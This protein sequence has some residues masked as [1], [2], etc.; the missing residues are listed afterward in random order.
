MDRRPFTT[1]QALRAEMR[2]RLAELGPEERRRGADAVAERVLGLEHLDRPRRLLS[3][4]SYGIE[5]DTRRLVDR[6]LAAGHEVYV[7]RAAPPS[8]ALSV[9]RYPCDLER[10][11]FGLEQPLAGAVGLADDEIGEVLD[12]VLILGLAFDRRGYRLG[13]GGGF[14]DRFLARHPV[15]AVGLAFELQIVDRLP[16]EPHDRPMQQIVTE[17]GVLLP[18]EG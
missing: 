15:H 18:E 8:R 12:L 3:C 17:R 16:I 14:F 11:A 9:H 6:L 1:K 2:A 7:P 10:L 5:I 4:L 13:H